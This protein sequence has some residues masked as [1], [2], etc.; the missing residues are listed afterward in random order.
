[1]RLKR[2]WIRLTI[3]LSLWIPASARS[4]PVELVNAFPNLKFTKPLFVTHSKDGTDRIF[5]VQ[6]NG[7]I[8]AF[9]NDSAV[10][11]YSTFLDISNKISSSSGEEGLLGLAFDPNYAENGYFF[12]DYTAPNPRR[13]VIARY[14][15]MPENSNK[16]DSLSELKI[17]EINQPFSNHNGGM[18]M[19][20][21]DGY[22]YIGMG[23]G[24]SGGDPY[25]NG[26]N[27]GVLLGK[28][29]RINVDSADGTMNY[30]IPPDNPLKGNTQG[31][32][33]EIYTWGMRNPWR[34]SQDPVTGQIWVGDVG[35]D[36]WEE[37]DLLEKGLNYGWRIMEGTHCYNPRAGCDETGLTL[38]IKEYPHA[39][40]DCSITGGYVY[41]GK[42]RPD[43]VGAYIYGDYC[44]GR[45]WMLRYQGGQVTTDSL[46]IQ[47]PF[48]I[49]SFGVDKENELYVC[50]YSDG[51]IHRFAR[52]P[53]SEGNDLD[54]TVPTRYSLEQNYPNPF[55]PGTTISFS[56]P[57]SS[58]VTLKVYNTLGQEVASLVNGETAAGGHEVRWDAG[59]TPSG[60]YFYQLRAGEFQQMQ[61][62]VLMKLAFRSAT[63]SPLEGEDRF[64]MEFLGE[65]V[66]RT[67]FVI[68]FRKLPVSS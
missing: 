18:L 38:P 49:S 23:D 35:Q 39:S 3:I 4:Q 44:T 12:V 17:L 5:V 54:V 36:D 48:Q 20:G 64:P 61:K 56:L 8:R 41:R 11:A 6:Q 34:F 1:M 7:F 46:L 26:Q 2:E 47:A 57:K 31:S 14:S 65:E 30:S 21:E 68:F 50:D 59:N 60:V 37:I 51:T 22:L 33:E 53:L 32:K 24:G 67:S 66:R 40:G 62:M 43:L 52:G 63:H 29:L 58:F 45:I 42:N 25:G 10:S 13:T 28:I 55:N 9:A 27:L 15:V 16:A 19:F